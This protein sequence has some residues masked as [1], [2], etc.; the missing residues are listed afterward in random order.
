LCEPVAEAG[1]V[2]VGGVGQDRRGRQLPARGLLTEIAS[3]LR[4]RPE[5]DL[6]RD[7]RLAAARQVVAPLL[8]QVQRPAKRLRPPLA[9]RMHADRDLAVADLAERA[10][11][12]ALHPRRMPAVLDDPG[13]IDNPSDDTKPR[14]HPLCTPANEQPRLPGRVSEKLLQRLVPCRRLFQPKQCRLQALPTTLLNQPAHIHKRVLT[15]PPQRQWT[16]HIFDK[17]DQPLAHIN[18]RHLDRKRSLHPPL[19]PTMTADTDTVR[20]ERRGPSNEL[21]KSY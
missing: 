9:D 12:L 11:V 6:V 4:L 5:D 10:R 20:G 15:L 21:T 19:L 18:H 13:V 8:W 2:A 14:R 16:R 3:K 17:A 7:L 1:I